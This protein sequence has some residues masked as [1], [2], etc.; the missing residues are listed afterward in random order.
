M[1]A[2]PAI[3]SVRNLVVDVPSA[4]GATR[5]LDGISFDVFPN[6][7]LGLVGESGSGKS[8]TMLAVM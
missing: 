8:L 3:L 4:N 2:E 6:E 7:V 1:T 5:L